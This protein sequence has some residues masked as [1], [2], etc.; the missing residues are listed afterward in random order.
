MPFEQAADRIAIRA[1]VNATLAHLAPATHVGKGNAAQPV[2][3]FVNLYVPR[4]HAMRL[5]R[6]QDTGKSASD[7]PD[8]RHERRN[9]RSTEAF[10]KG[11]I[12]IKRFGP[13][14]QTGTGKA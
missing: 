12:A 11:Y 8:A 5:H 7:N 2:E 10:G 14:G 13:H 9:A 4:T 3:P 6:G 1:E